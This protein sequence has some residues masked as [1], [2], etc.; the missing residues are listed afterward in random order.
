MYILILDE[1]RALRVNVTYIQT[2]RQTE[3]ATNLLVWGFV[4][5]N[6]CVQ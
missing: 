6:T 5:I 4:L 1:C 3:L 2:G